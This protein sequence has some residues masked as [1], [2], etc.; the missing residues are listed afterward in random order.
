MAFKDNYLSSW[1]K[2]LQYSWISRINIMKMALQLKTIYRFSA[3]PIK[4]PVSFFVEIEK[5]VLKFI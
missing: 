5:L 1:W 3:M 4:I 2:D